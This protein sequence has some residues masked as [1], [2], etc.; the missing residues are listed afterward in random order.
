MLW[1]TWKKCATIG[2]DQ[3]AVTRQNRLQHVGPMKIA[4]SH[5]DTVMELHILVKVAY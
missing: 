1:A 5:C 4:M 2:T 3:T